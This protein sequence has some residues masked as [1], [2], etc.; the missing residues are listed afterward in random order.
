MTTCFSV[1][2]LV[3]GLVETPVIAVRQF[4]IKILRSRL[5]TVSQNG[6][7]YEPFLHGLWIDSNGHISCE[8]SSYDVAGLNRRIASFAI[9]VRA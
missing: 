8:G 6:D 9:S 7:G 5:Y 4:D 2:S 3:N 1:I